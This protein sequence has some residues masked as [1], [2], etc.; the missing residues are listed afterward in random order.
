M[1]SQGSDKEDECQKLNRLLEELATSGEDQLDAS[2]MKQ[3]KKICK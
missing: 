2:K 3:V 1:A